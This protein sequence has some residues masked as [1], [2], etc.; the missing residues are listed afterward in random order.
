[1]IG[2]G[3]GVIS[4]GISVYNVA[5]ADNKAQAVVEETGALTG[6]LLGVNWEQ[7]L[8]LP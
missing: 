7:R 6:Q 1:M 5:T 4:I 3:L 8:V 2:K